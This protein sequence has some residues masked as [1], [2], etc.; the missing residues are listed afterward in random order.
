MRPSSEVL[1]VLECGMSCVGS[2]TLGAVQSTLSSCVSS[3][4]ARSSSHVS[5][6]LEEVEGP[7]CLTAWTLLHHQLQ[8]MA[9][10]LQSWEWVCCHSWL[11]HRVMPG[12][13]V[14]PYFYLFF[15]VIISNLALPSSPTFVASLH[16]P[17]T[18]APFAVHLTYDLPLRYC[19]GCTYL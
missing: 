4:V 13:V 14:I 8:E 5:A 11:Y 6:H 3:R 9:L 18:S 16:Y 2:L 12:S 10:G 19:D 7:W 1:L 17:F 15:P